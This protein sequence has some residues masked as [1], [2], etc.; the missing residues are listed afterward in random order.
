[1]NQSDSMANHS[2]GRHPGSR[3]TIQ[4]REEMLI[5]KAVDADGYQLFW[6]HVRK[7]LIHMYRTMVLSVATSRA[8]RNLDI[9]LTLVPPKILFPYEGC[10]HYLRHVS[11]IG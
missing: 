7:L 11:T 1:M 3:A 2:H 6:L 8:V 10:L 5:Q 4:Q 9:T